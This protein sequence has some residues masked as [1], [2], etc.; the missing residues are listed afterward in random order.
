[1]A[2]CSATVYVILM[3]VVN[4]EVF[5]LQKI[6]IEKW[7]QQH[8]SVFF[9]VGNMFGLFQHRGHCPTDR[10]SLFIRNS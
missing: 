3:S 1:M 10:F 9:I 5:L 7:Q 6:I 2:V 4:L 8:D